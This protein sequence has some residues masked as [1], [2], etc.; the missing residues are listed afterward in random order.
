MSETG[1]GPRVKVALFLPPSAQY[2]KGD[3]VFFEGDSAAEVASLLEDAIANGGLIEKAVEA[4]KVYLV[5][6]GLGANSTAGSGGEGA[7]VVPFPTSAPQEEIRT[8]PHGKLG[9]REGDNNRGHW[10]GWFCPL[11]KGDPN[12]CRP[13][14]A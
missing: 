8:C 9:R 4:A 12:R 2:A 13:Q 5:E 14:F 10:V 1:S 6:S 11:P 3:G 7:Q